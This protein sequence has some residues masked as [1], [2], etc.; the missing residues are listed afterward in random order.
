[1][2]VELAARYVGIGVTLLEEQGLPAK[3]IGR[4]KLYDR[5]DLD[6]WADRLDGQPVEE[7]EAG[8]ESQA[9][10]RRFLERRRKGKGNAQ[11]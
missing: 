3:R 5:L 10:E 8:D 1:M 2:P 6:R 9:T 4:R 7:G 11:G